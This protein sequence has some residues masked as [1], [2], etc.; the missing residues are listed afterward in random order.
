M[1]FPLLTIYFVHFLH[2]NP[3]WWS[4]TASARA[5]SEHCSPMW[6]HKYCSFPNAT[7]KHPACPVSHCRTHHAEAGRADFAAGYA[8]VSSVGEQLVLV[9]IHHQFPC[10]ICL[11][12]GDEVFCCG[13]CVAGS[14][15]STDSSGRTSSWLVLRNLTPQVSG[16]ACSEMCKATCRVQETIRF[17]SWADLVHLKGK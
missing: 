3:T 1:F 17:I 8:L 12:H 14:A 2:Q 6:L 7:N 16:T 5:S 11:L 4:D 15:W 10:C 13:I 9:V